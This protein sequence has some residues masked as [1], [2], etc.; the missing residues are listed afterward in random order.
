MSSDYVPTHHDDDD[1]DVV[2]TSL[3]ER[4]NQDESKEGDS[5]FIVYSWTLLMVEAA[6]VD[7]LHNNTTILR[8]LHIMHL[9]AYLG[10]PTKV[11]YWY[12][13]IPTS[14]SFLLSFFG[15]KSSNKLSLLEMVYHLL[16]LVELT[17]RLLVWLFIATPLLV[18]GS[19]GYTARL[20]LPVYR[21][22]GCR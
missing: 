8:L 9:M 18:L 20:L 6:S 15:Q 13:N 14:A 10:L 19:L 1:D 4:S 21:V 7:S 22:Y 2:I 5:E 3:T 11:Q 12:V 16:A 17:P